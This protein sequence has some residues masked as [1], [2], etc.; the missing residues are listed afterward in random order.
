MIWAKVKL[1]QEILKKNPLSFSRAE[2]AMY[3]E[4][5]MLGQSLLSNIKLL[6]GWGRPSIINASGITARAIRPV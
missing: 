5:P 2:A 1:P 6:E 4:F 3:R